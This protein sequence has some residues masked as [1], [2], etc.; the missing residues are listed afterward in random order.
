MTAVAVA[1]SRLAHFPIVF[2]ATVMGLS[3]LALAVTRAEHA[4]GRSPV[5]GTIVATLALLVFVVIA[6]TYVLKVLRHPA[7]VVAEWR[8]PVRMAFFP[9]AAISLILL[10][11]ALQP[12]L[13]ALAQPLWAAGAALQLIGSLSVVS[14]WIGHRAFETPQLTPAWFIPAV[15]NV[16]VPIA[17]VG[18]GAIEVSWFFLSVGLVF[19]LILLTLVFNRLIFH[20]PM[21]DRLL[22]TLAILVAPPAVAF[23]SWTRLGGGLDPFGRIL[24]DA[25]VLFALVVLT[26]AGR[27]RQIGFAMSWW[28]YSFPLAA[29]TVA[30]FVYGELSGSAAHVGAGF[31]LAALTT[32]VIGAL[33][34][35]T[36]VGM[37]RDE[38]CR[39]E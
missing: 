38:I 11:T 12:A 32:T 30:T 29:L 25:A 13:P 4:L 17:G 33:A 7:M 34:I 5:A 15:G 39:P 2:F 16:L 3:G 22:P 26:Q 35:R 21:P 19:W 31:G 9:A 37:M 10:G 28:A 20:P 6:A 36:V 14:V 24:Y 23:L 18:Y 8:H 1:H 27:L